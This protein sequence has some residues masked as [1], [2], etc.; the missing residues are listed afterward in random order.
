M[1]RIT[2]VVATGR[3]DLPPVEPQPG[4]CLG[5][6]ETRGAHDLHG[7]RPGPHDDK[8]PDESAEA[9][10]KALALVPPAPPMQ[11]AMRAWLA[12]PNKP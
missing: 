9:L 3:A 1:S 5:R 11:T 4:D 12:E 8:H 2:F 10:Q 7:A 6:R